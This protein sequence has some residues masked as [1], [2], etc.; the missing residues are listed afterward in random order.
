MNKRKIVITLLLSFLL[1]AACVTQNNP[2][3]VKEIQETESRADEETNES[4]QQIME[5]FQSLINENAS[6]T[7]VAE[8]I[9]TTISSVSKENA[10]IMMKIFEEMQKGFLPILEEKYFPDLIQKKLVDSNGKAEKGNDEELSALLTKTVDSGFK[11]ETA[12]GMYFPIIDYGFYKKYYAYV[13]PDYQDYIDIMAIESNKVPAKDAALVISWEEV[14]E[15]A[16]RQENFITNH[17]N[18]EKM[19]EINELYEKYLVFA[20]YG[21]NNTPLFE[22]D[23]NTLRPEAKAD[24]MKVIENNGDLKTAEIVQDFLAIVQKHDDI[25]TDEVEEFRSEYR[26]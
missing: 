7:G 4:E 3:D 5:D 18:S 1:L 13:T 17:P 19:D 20:L 8:Y 2:S 23:T 6:L 16:I 21:L 22:Y 25:L 10:S 9:D 26:K 11:V 14:L 12:E 15:R 24:Y